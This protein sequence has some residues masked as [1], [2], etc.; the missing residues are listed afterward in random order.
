MATMG[1]W[2]SRIEAIAEKVEAG[3]RLTFEEGVELFER[4]PVS[5]RLIVGPNRA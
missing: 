4:V 5:P 1:Q 2:S 3:E